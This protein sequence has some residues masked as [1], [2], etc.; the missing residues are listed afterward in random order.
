M[1]VSF[2]ANMLSSRSDSLSIL[3]HATI[4]TLFD[5]EAMI[6]EGNYGVQLFM[7]GGI[8]ATL[9]LMGVMVFRRKDLPL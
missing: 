8:A 4:I 7:L 1:S 6:Q 9:Y 2:V 3:E 5:S